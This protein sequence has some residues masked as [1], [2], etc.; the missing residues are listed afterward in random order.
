M[1]NKV[2]QKK[3]Y[4]EIHLVEH[5]NLN[6]KGC[7]HFAPLAQEEYIQ[8]ENFVKDI[9]RIKKITKGDLLFVKLLGGEP[10]LHPEIK[11]LVCY[12]RKTFPKVPIRLLTN[13]MLLLN[14]QKDFLDI[15]RRN[16]VILEITKYPIE[17]E[18]EELH[19]ILIQSKVNF[20]YRG[21]TNKEEKKFFHIHLDLEG[22]QNHNYSFNHCMWGNGAICLKDGKLFTCPLPAYINHFNQY[23]KKNIPVCEEDYVDIYKVNKVEEILERLSTAPKFC[24]F[25]D[26]GGGEF[27]Y[28]SKYGKSERNI[29]EW[30]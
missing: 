11:E 26:V 17:F 8:M 15:C 18:Y 25:C 1:K 21:N 6:C 24:R 13:G 2:P 10:L 14:K 16:D 20:V 22:N 28:D 7:S 9:D 5:C 23:F 30:L 12:V 4:F 27:I 29:N 3:L 19:R